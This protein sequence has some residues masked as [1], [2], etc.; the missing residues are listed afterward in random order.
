MVK[1]KNLVDYINEKHKHMFMSCLGTSN[2][3]I[4]WGDLN[5][6]LILRF[7][8]SCVKSGLT[9]NNYT[10]YCASVRVGTPITSTEFQKLE[11]ISAEVDRGI[12]R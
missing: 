3:T 11:Q 12:F 8:T 4:D 7:G 5:E 1:G 9:F 10:E 6:D 2:K